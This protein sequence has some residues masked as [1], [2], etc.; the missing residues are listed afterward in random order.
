MKADSLH[1]LSEITHEWQ[2]ALVPLR[3]TERRVFRHFSRR[4]IFLH[5]S[6]VH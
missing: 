4:V 1:A 5:D 6:Q 3:K 2:V